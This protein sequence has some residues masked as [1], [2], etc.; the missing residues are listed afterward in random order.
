MPINEN[1]CI[2]QI[3]SELTG[4]GFNLNEAPKTKDFI[5]TIVNNVLAEIKKGTVST[6][7][8]GTSATGGPVTGTG[9]GTIS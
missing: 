7:V 6:Q 8:T 1:N 4:K 5:E 9:T 3:Q 2:S